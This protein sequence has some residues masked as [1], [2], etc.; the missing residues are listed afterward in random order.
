MF[1]YWLYQYRDNTYILL[2][3]SSKQYLVVIYLKRKYDIR[4]TK[5]FLKSKANYD[6]TERGVFYY[7]AN[8]DIKKWFNENT[9]ITDKGV[10]KLKEES[11]LG[12]L[13]KMD[14]LSFHS[15]N[16]RRLASLNYFIKDY[17]RVNP[18]KIS[19]KLLIKIT[20]KYLRVSHKVAIR[21]AVLLYTICY[22]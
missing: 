4:F 17:L 16:H 20:E 22:V 18:A 2:Y 14:V 12:S 11:T 19:M 21:I 3:P 15:V 10:F 8:T 13:Y 7:Y 6:E 1:L 9:E 5:K